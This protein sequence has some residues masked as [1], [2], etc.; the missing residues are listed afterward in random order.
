MH[1]LSLTWSSPDARVSAKSVTLASHSIQEVHANCSRT[2]LPLR[3]ELTLFAL[4]DMSLAL[5]PVTDLVQRFARFLDLDEDE[6]GLSK[7]Q[8]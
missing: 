7:C 8:G 1:Y 5:T 2:A 6:S 4:A 3:L